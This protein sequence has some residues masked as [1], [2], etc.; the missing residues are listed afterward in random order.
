LG[1]DKIAG[2]VR[3]FVILILRRPNAN[4]VEVQQGGRQPNLK[5]RREALMKIGP[6]KY[7]RALFLRERALEMVCRHGIIEIIGAGG[8]GRRVHCDGFSVWYTDPETA[9][10]DEYYH[11]DVYANGCGKVLNVIWK[12]NDE[13]EEINFNRGTWEDY[14]LS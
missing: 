13:P 9:E 2:F 8:F 5:G 10:S 12:D 7:E 6:K 11:L 3:V 4:H 14:F 1:G